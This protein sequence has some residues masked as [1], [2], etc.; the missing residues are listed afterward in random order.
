M[1]QIHNTAI[2]TGLKRLKGPFWSEPFVRG[3]QEK[4]E[5]GRKRKQRKREEKGGIL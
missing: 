5:N 1:S 3:G 2:K 4:E